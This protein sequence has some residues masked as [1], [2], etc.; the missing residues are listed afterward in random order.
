MTNLLVLPELG[1]GP[2]TWG[3]VWG[4]LTAPRQHPPSLVL[5]PAVGAV[6]TI[7]FN[8]TFGDGRGVRLA[9]AVD[10]VADKAQAMG[11]GPRIAVAHGLSAAILL[12][13]LPKWNTAP[14]RV[15]LF[16]GAAPV[17]RGA[18]R[19]ALPKAT[20]YP[21]RLLSPLHRLLRRRLTI[22]Q[23]M[24]YGTL[25]NGMET[26]EV[27]HYVAYF[28]PLPLRWLGTRLTVPQGIAADS[29]SYVVLERDRLLPPALQRD[30][31][32]LLGARDITSLDA[33]HQAML[34]RPAQVAEIIRQVA[35]AP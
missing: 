27:V 29:L 10:H 12:A 30:Q 8:A 18:I 34:Q 6:T 32:R 7:D 1:Q 21:L 13:S 16:A 20:R 23:H 28:R 14:D 33:C 15:V 3:P 19:N 25:C 26:M 4:H 17:P 5:S 35:L 11:S 9:D 2:E 31:A 22:P 24:I